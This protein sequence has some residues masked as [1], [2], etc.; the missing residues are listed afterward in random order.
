VDLAK[1][2]KRKAQSEKRKVQNER[3]KTKSNGLKLTPP[4]SFPLPFCH[5]RESGNLGVKN[6]KDKMDSH[7]HG[8]DK[9]G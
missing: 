5:S 4:L 8:N 2:A 3:H 9:E 7:F 1:S 6:E